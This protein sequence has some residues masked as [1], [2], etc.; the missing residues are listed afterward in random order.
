MSDSLPV[1]YSHLPKILAECDLK[2][3]DLHQKLKQAGIRVNQKSLYRLTTSKPI[4]KV[5]TRI[6]GAI[7]KTCA[8]NIQDVIVFEKPKARLQKLSTTEQRRLDE[9]MSKHSE[10]QL[11]AD[12]VREFDRLS[13]KA[14]DL[15]MA[16]A[17]VLLAQRRAL[18]SGGGQGGIHRSL[19]PLRPVS[20]PKPV[21]RAWQHS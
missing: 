18:K 17:R 11:S 9:L 15:T 1:A 13:E 19:R 20:V 4:Q 5:D 10:G 14:H 3:S 21:K 16:N 8:V 2:I 12:Q 6:L 7:C